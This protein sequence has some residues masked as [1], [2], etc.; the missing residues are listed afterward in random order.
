MGCTTN[1]VLACEQTSSCRMNQTIFSIISRKHSNDGSTL[2]FGVRPEAAAS[3]L[4][5]TTAKR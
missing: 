3:V 5:T 2:P 4:F 1:D